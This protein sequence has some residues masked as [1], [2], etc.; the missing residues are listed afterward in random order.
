MKSKIA[1]LVVLLFCAATLSLADNSM[2]GYISDSHCGAKGAKEGHAECVTKCVKEHGAKYVF[3]D[4]KDHK[5]Y[6]IADQSKVADHAGHHVTVQ[7]KV[8]GDT[9]TVDSISMAK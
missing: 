2:T 3:V 4:D 9:L 1:A 5:V 8:E 6:N 7:G